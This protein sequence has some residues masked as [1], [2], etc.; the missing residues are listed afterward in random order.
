FK[1]Q[2]DANQKLREELAAARATTPPEKA[3]RALAKVRSK[4]RKLAIQ[5]LE[6]GIVGKDGKTYFPE[7][8]LAGGGK[9]GLDWKEGKARYEN[10]L[11]P[12]TGLH[13]PQGQFTSTRDIE[14]AVQMAADNAPL[15][16]KGKSFPLP[17]DSTSFV[18]MRVNG[19]VVPVRADS[20]W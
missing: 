10:E 3:A 7:A 6:K 18:W 8:G 2:L 19:E 14:Y 12:Y 13:T 9:P 1:T 16:P 17:P 15:P 20:V 5:D 4:L 11:D